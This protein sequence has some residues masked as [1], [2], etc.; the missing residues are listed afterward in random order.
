MLQSWHVSFC[1]SARFSRIVEHKK[2]Y[3]ENAKSPLYDKLKFC[4]EKEQLNDSLIYHASRYSC[5]IR[6]QALSH[7]LSILLVTLQN[8]RRVLEEKRND[9]NNDRKQ[10]V[11]NSCFQ[12]ASLFGSLA[13]HHLQVCTF[14]PPHQQLCLPHLCPILHL[15]GL[16]DQENFFFSQ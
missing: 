13:S 7:L 3:W 14:P 1:E 4:A 10:S 6:P 5:V 8:V 16:T 2:S 9:S 11:K 15:L 12:N